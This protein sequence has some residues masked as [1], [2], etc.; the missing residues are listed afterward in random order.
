MVM[1]AGAKLF[2]RTNTTLDTIFMSTFH[3]SM[4]IWYGPFHKMCAVYFGDSLLLL[5]MCIGVIIYIWLGFGRRPT[6]EFS[7][8]DIKQKVLHTQKSPE[9]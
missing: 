5:R 8:D 3:L 2:A 1:A 6:T 4:M 7:Y 9:A